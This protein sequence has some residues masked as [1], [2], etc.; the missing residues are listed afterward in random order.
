MSL[1]AG[2]ESW[3][4]GVRKSWTPY[5]HSP[6]PSVCTS[7]RAGR[8]RRTRRTGVLQGASRGGM[9]WGLCL[10]SHL[11]PSFLQGRDGLPG[12]PGPPGPPGPKVI[13]SSRR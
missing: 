12:L 6:H 5:Q 4:N 9:T 8:E 10:G 11:S 2:W 3:G 13:T 1:G 7:G